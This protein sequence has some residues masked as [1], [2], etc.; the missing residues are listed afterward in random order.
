M[1]KSTWL[2][3]IEITDAARIFPKTFMAGYAYL[4]YKTFMW[5]TILPEPS[6]S[7]SAFASA[8]I[9]LATIVTG[10]YFQTGRK[11]PNAD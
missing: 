6:A 8:I 7:Q 5:Y 10:W 11:W 9:G 1:Q 4:L 3:F 2:N